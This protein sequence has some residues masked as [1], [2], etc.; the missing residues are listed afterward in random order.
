VT[1]ILARLD[2]G[3]SAA[4]AELLPLVYEELRKLAHARM[5][6][7]PPGQTL[8]PTGL[9]H[10][11]Y[12]KLVSGGDEKAP[13]NGRAHFFGAAAQA[14]RDILVDAARKKAALKH[15]GA[16]ERVDWDSSRITSVVDDGAARE[17]LISLDEALSKLRAAHPRQAEVT[18]L[19]MFAGLTDAEIATMQDVTERTIERDFRF[20][21]AFLLR[22]L[23]R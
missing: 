21:Q 12:V 17:D 19:K 8:Q 3:E 20:A 6:K 10:E 2:R 13:W 23:A 16:Q 18:M 1:E 9:V 15:G 14:M 5:Q 22:E 4:A 7:I 11:A